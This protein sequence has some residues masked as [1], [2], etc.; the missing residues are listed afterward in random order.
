MGSGGIGS[1]ITLVNMLNVP[2]ILYECTTVNVR[3][4]YFYLQFAHSGNYG[5]IISYT[6]FEHH[7]TKEITAVD[8]KCVAAHSEHGGT[9]RIHSFNT[10]LDLLC[11]R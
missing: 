4:F 6:L 3:L 10:V 9:E 7:K 1:H 5:C 2:S 11:E 8:P